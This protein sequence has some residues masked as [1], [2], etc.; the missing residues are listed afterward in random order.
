MEPS[1]CDRAASLRQS[2]LT[3]ITR[4]EG[5]PCRPQAAASH[6]LSRVIHGAPSKG[7]GQ[8]PSVARPGGR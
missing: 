2:G 8:Q 1:H 4:K 5:A 7:G 3:D 6:S